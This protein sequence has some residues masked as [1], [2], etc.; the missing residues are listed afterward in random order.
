MGFHRQKFLLYV[1]P[2]RSVPYRGILTG[3]ISF[4]SHQENKINARCF[5]IVYASSSDS[6]EN[7]HGG[8]AFTRAESSA[9]RRV[10]CGLRAPQNLLPVHILHLVFSSLLIGHSLVVLVVKSPRLYADHMP[11]CYN[12][13]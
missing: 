8:Q 2:Y 9:S 1:V 5:I 3:S 6:A 7:F 13:Q 10:V 11:L 12:V 4:Y